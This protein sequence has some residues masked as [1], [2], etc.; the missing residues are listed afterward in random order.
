MRDGA[1]EVV[2]TGNLAF[3]ESKTMRIAPPVRIQ[4]SD[5]SL[6]VTVAGQQEGAIGSTGQPAQD[7][8]VPE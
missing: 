7:T 1:N 2:F 5:G 3:G 6:E 4:S 8:F